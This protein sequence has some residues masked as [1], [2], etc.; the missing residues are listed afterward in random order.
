M[1]LVKWKQFLAAQYR[2]IQEDMVQTENWLTNSEGDKSVLKKDVKMVQERQ[3]LLLKLLKNTQDLMERYS[4]D[5]DFVIKDMEIK[6][7]LFVREIR[8]KVQNQDAAIRRLESIVNKYR[9]IVRKAV[10]CSD[11]ENDEDYGD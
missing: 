9:S 6:Q 8:K 2:S 1:E 4:I 3:D 7:D 5:G 10:P 11:V